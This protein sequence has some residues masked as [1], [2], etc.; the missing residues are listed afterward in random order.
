MLYSDIKTKTK[1]IFQKLFNRNQS[2]RLGLVH[3]ELNYNY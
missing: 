1:K 3:H 2:T